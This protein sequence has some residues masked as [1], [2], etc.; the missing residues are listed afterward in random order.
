MYCSIKHFK[1]QNV[2]V[3]R[4]SYAKTLVFDIDETLLHTVQVE[5]SQVGKL[6]FTPDV[7]V[8]LGENRPVMAITFRPGLKD[9]LEALCD[10]FE[11][12]LFTAGTASYYKVLQTVF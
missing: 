9:L 5:A 8:E 1:M 6:K 10:K 4:S 2:F 11:I 12:I 7:V 3:K